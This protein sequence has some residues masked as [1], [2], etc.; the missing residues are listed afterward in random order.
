MSILGVKPLTLE[1]INEK[2]TSYYQVKLD[3]LLGEL[4]V[5]K[6]KGQRL[7]NYW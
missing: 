7:K 5:L 6:M 2:M 3:K 1:E 4:N